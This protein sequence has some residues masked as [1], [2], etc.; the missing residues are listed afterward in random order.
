MLQILGKV[1][2]IVLFFCVIFYT[3]TAVAYYY[4]LQNSVGE[5]SNPVIRATNCYGSYLRAY[6]SSN[7]LPGTEASTNQYCNTI[8]TFNL[9]TNVNLQNT[10]IK[11][12]Y[13]KKGSTCE[14]TTS[15]YSGFGPPLEYQFVNASMSV[16]SANTLPGDTTPTI[17]VNGAIPNSTVQLYSNSTCTS[18]ISSPVTSNA[19]GQASITTNTLTG[20]TTIYLK[21]GTLCTVSH[22]LF[23]PITGTQLSMTRNSPSIDRGTTLTPTFSVA[24]LSAYSGMIGRLRAKNLLTN[25][26]TDGPIATINSNTVLGAVTLPACLAGTNCPYLIFPAIAGIDHTYAGLN[27]TVDLTTPTTTS[28]TSLINNQAIN[29]T[30]NNASPSVKILGLQTDENYTV[31]LYSNPNCATSLASV[32]SN[33]SSTV[34][35]FPTIG[36][37]GSYTFSYKI[38]D[39]VGHASTCKN[40]AFSYR[41]D[42]AM[43]TIS[44][45]NFLQTNYDGTSTPVYSTWRNII[46]LR[47]TPSDNDGISVLKF[48]LTRVVNGQQYTA[49]LSSNSCTNGAECSVQ[50]DTGSSNAVSMFTNQSGVAL[51]GS[52]INGQYSLVTSISDLAGNVYSMSPVNVI[53]QNDLNPPT[54]NFLTPNDL[55]YSSLTSTTCANA[56]GVTYPIQVQ[57]SD[58]TMT[59]VTAH[60]FKNTNPASLPT[61]TNA[62]CPSAGSLVLQ[63]A[64][65]FQSAAVSSNIY[66]LNL[67]TMNEVNGNL[68]FMTVA[69][70]GAGRM[71]LPHYSCVKVSNASQDTTPPTGLMFKSGTPTT[72][73]GNNFII[74]AQVTDD[75]FISKVELYKNGAIYMLSSV[76]VLYSPPNGA[77][78]EYQFK[79]NTLTLP[80]GSYPFALRACDT[81]NNCTAITSALNITINNANIFYQAENYTPISGLTFPIASSMNGEIVVSFPLGT[82]KFNWINYTVQPR[83][84]VNNDY[85]LYVK[86]RAKD[87]NVP[88]G[89]KVSLDNGATFKT[90]SYRKN[91]T[92]KWC[93]FQVNSSTAQKFKVDPANPKTIQFKFN[94]S[95]LELDKFILVPSSDTSVQLQ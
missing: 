43:P 13:V 95:N 78:F 91:T 71:S 69:C 14:T 56:S 27:Y 37:D 35:I 51:S 25:T 85:Y 16:N 59:Q 9:V 61:L 75:T 26:Y 89:L 81:N 90:M 55:S 7:C 49:I 48:T 11:S 22:P 66:S 52:S 32:N 45:V 87:G 47:V 62:N 82:S 15:Y 70:D 77:P 42:R 58:D 36:V 86:I 67:N 34:Q 21:T 88:T 41:L 92:P 64:S 39:Q 74:T 2:F 53:I 24:N 30:S 94:N 93:R 12:F 31:E 8:A 57:V 84:A 63:G 5:S 23:Y 50:F 28:T 54:V 20:D 38:I 29:Q 44:N 79:I 80:N 83:Y 17:I 60:I 19:N 40:F 6:T 65:S 10:Q 1:K 33:M 46:N 73:S 76:P 4:S 18:S 72:A 3:Q 68:Y